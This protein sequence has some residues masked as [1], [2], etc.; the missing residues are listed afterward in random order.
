M[1][2]LI[3]TYVLTIGG[4]A[5]APFYP[6][7][8]FLV[9]VAFASLKP[10]YLWHWSV[11]MGNYSRV[12]G[13]AFLLGWLLNGAGS[14]KKTPANPILVALG[15]Y[16][17]L[18]VL[19]AILSPAQE[20]AWYTLD[21]LTKV[22]LP[23]VAG[24]TLINSIDRLKQLA[25]VL[26]LSHGV[27][28]IQFNQQY[29]S[30]GI[31]TDE[32]EFAGADNNSI[33]ITMVTAVGLAFFLGLA[34]KEWWQKGIAFFLAL[35]MAH[36]VL[37]SMS[38][39]GM[40]AMC[41]S[42]ATAFILMPKRP[43][44]YVAMGGAVILVLALAGEG[45]RQEF[46]S[47]FQETEKLDT[48]AL[49]R[50]KFTRDAAHCMLTHPILGCGLENWPNVA[51]EYG[52]PK[53]RRAHNTWM[54][55]GATLGFPGLIAILS[56]YGICC[57]QMVR[58]SRLKVPEVDRW[59]V[60]MSRGVVSALVGFFGSAWFVTSDRIEL[61]YYIVLL[62]AGMLKVAAVKGN[63]G[64]AFAHRTTARAKRTWEGLPHPSTPKPPSLETA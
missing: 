7:Y 2:G 4:A 56:F 8:G 36:V 6:F 48:S 38:R 29:Y 18:L 11:P 34:S 23:L 49:S 53:G 5:I 52:W 3:I 10:D 32:W 43:I 22:F 19:G 62:G 16:W 50:F 63:W 12:V 13:A 41:L 40:L 21:V 37:F 60:W 45:V 58:L 31:N 46:M 42:G 14:F 55:I 9:Y 51:P 47:S 30:F 59:S 20:E 39:G 24:F 17:A 64:T 61:P 26:V 35:L 33:A 57:W 25:W 27:L 15:C 54:E 1:K 44:S 28:A